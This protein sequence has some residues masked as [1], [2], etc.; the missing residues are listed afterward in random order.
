MFTVRIT[1]QRF[2]SKAE[3]EKEARPVDN[4]TEQHNQVSVLG[5]DR[6]GKKW[7]WAGKRIDWLQETLSSSRTDN[8]LGTRQVPANT[9]T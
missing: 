6:S 3:T 9:E 8:V 4:G 2:E 1:N 5:P 7:K